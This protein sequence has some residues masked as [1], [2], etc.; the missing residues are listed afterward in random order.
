MGHSGVI[1][2]FGDKVYLNTLE[3]IREAF[4]SLKEQKEEEGADA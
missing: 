3:I 4:N 1:A 2:K